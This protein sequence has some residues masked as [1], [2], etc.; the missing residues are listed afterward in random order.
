MSKMENEVIIQLL[1]NINE[2]NLN[3]PNADN[4]NK[5][6]DI[7]EKNCCI[8]AVKYA[9]IG[10]AYK[11]RINNVDVYLVK[12]ENNGVIKTY[13]YTRC[14]KTTQEGNTL[15]HLHSRMDKL[16]HDGLKIFER[17]II[18]REINDKSRCLA[19]INDDFFENMGKRGAKKK[20]G[21][22]NYLFN[23]EN[24]PILLILNHKNAKLSTQLTIFATQ[25][26]KNNNYVG[27]NT[28]VSNEKSKKN[29]DIISSLD[30]KET[31]QKPEIIVKSI[32]SSKEEEE[33]EDEDEDEEEDE[34]DEE[35]EEDEED[36]EDE[37]EEKSCIEIFTISKK[38]LYLDPTDNSI[39]EPEEDDSGCPIGILTEISKDHHQIIHEDK[40]CT[41][42]KE[43]FHKK[44]N[45]VYC[46]VI[47]DSLFDKDLNFIGTR[48][49][50]K[51]NEY[52]FKFIK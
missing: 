28:S 31:I 19:N 36:D 10:N 18:P 38:N 52:K 24:H 48:K 17:D 11:D 33:E 2:K 42:L 3:V 29:N 32:I 23:D 8:A 12:D 34:E 27:N 5:K 20:N 25:L 7:N 1:N 16:N 9:T 50:I 15:C 47:T 41:V 46:C 14:S 4:K 43:S 13:A 49:K 26:L 35:E 51:N 44:Y 45:K 21:D 37:L 6:K 30:L 40:F 22:N 39:Y